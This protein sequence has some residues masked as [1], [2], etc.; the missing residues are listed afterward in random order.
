[1]D[2][3]DGSF[4]TNRDQW[5]HV[6]LQSGHF[7]GEEDLPQKNRDRKGELPGRK[8]REMRAPAKM[9]S[10]NT[11]QFLGGWSMLR[12]VLT[13]F[14]LVLAAMTAWAGPEFSGSYLVSTASGDMT[15]TLD[16]SSAGAVTGTLM[17]SDGD[18]CRVSGQTTVDEDSEWSVEG[19]IACADGRSDF[20]FSKDEG[21]EFVL[22]LVPYDDSGT[23]RSEL[24]AVLYARRQDADESTTGRT[25]PVGP[26]TSLRDAALLGIWATQV[27]T[28]TPGGSMTTQMFMEFRD[29]G[30]L[31]DLGSR[32]VGGIPGVS[33]DTGLEGGGD[34]AGWRTSGN[35]LQVRYAGSDWMTL[36][37]YA[38][39]GNQVLFVY[40]DGDRKIWYRQ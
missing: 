17:M 29:D 3:I 1:V 10:E 13:V 15:L 14:V 21:D 25:G 19:W 27:V 12:S 36:A 37:S 7:A 4:R 39:S 35:L 31:V 24:A 2:F 33:A 18:S 16:Q 20:E 9:A 34:I 6:G 23:P 38:V 30:T 40:Y 32:S 5:T 8:I 28:S 11:H 26:S 22:V